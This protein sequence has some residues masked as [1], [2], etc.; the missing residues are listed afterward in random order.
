VNGAGTRAENLS[1]PREFCEG[2]AGVSENPVGGGNESGVEVCVMV[3]FE[4]VD[5]KHREYAKGEVAGEG[6]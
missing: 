2:R 1:S 3:M 4:S 5:G 6:D